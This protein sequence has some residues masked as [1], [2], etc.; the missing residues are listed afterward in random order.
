MVPQRARAV[1]SPAV[2]LADD[3][4]GEKHDPSRALGQLQREL[5]LG[6]FFPPVERHA[7]PVP[8]D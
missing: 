3:L 4:T 7:A 1:R 5:A 6:A 2:R 8:Q